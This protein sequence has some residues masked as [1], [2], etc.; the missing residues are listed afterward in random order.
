M[1][2]L[3]RV[4]LVSLFISSILIISSASAAWFDNGIIVSGGWDTESHRVVADGE[5]GAKIGRASCRERV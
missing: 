1:T 3:W 4:L 2:P 5:G